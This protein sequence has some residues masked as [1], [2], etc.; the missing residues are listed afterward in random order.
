MK[1]RKSGLLL[2]S[3]RWRDCSK[4]D[5][6]TLREERE[7]EKIIEEEE[8]DGTSAVLS[9]DDLEDSSSR[10]SSITSR[11]SGG[12]TICVLVHLRTLDKQ[13]LKMST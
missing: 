8:T 11:I 3:S 13:R 4:S 2:R 6:R 1:E 5:S 12:K 10:L 9:N 7:C